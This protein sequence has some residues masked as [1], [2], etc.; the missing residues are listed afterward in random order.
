MGVGNLHG[1]ES[2]ASPQQ[3]RSRHLRGVARCRPHWHPVAAVCRHRFVTLPS[4][5]HFT[6]FF[7]KVKAPWIRLWEFHWCFAGYPVLRSKMEFKAPGKAANKDDWNKFLMAT[8]VCLHWTTGSCCKR[9]HLNHASCC[10]CHTASSV[11][12]SSSS[13]EPGVAPLPTQVTHS[14]NLTI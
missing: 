3:G 14:S 10:R 4:F 13:S 7:P 11:V 1:S 12:T 9:H 5:V 6:L 8:K 2:R